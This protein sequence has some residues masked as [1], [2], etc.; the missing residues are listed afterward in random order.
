MS[1]HIARWRRCLLTIML[2]CPRPVSTNAGGA[3]VSFAVDDHRMDPEYKRLEGKSVVAVCCEA[4]ELRWSCVS[5]CP[6]V[7][8]G[9]AKVK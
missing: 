3:S 5:R 6:V 1:S 8:V 4:R 9:K 7:S 2:A